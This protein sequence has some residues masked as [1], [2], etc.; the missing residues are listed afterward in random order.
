MWK[1]IGGCLLVCA[2][3]IGFGLWSGYRKLATFGSGDGTETVMI[4]APVSRV[5][6][7]LANSDSLSTWMAEH[8]GMKAG[9]HGMLV[10]GDTLQGQMRLRFNVG[11]KPVKWTVSEVTPGQLLTLQLRSDSSGKLIARRQF[12]LSAKGDSTRIT[13][14]VAAPMLDSMRVNRADS[15]TPSEAIIDVTSKLLMSALRMQSHV[16]LQQLKTRV[17][18]H[19]SSRG[20]Q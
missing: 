10:A 4:A 19:S 18:G 16:E 5:F 12:T 15:V 20:R 2:A 11:N 17:E 7:S 8:T 3:V 13:S 1:W 9:H 6:A 14:A